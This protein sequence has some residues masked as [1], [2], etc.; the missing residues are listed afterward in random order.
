ALPLVVGTGAEG[1]TKLLLAQMGRYPKISAGVKAYVRVGDRRWDLVMRNGVTLMLPE[2]RIDAALADVAAM[3]AKAE[4]LT[5]DIAAVDMRLEDRVVVRLTPEAMAQRVEY[6][7]ARDK[8]PK[9]SERR[10]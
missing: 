4:L 6:L 9:R 2:H 8:A 7:K 1:Q 3:D 10:V 5:R